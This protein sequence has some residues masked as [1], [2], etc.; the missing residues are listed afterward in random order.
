M[1]DAK[2]RKKQQWTWKK[3]LNSEGMYTL[4]APLHYL[5]LYQECVDLTNKEDAPTIYWIQ[6]LTLFPSD[7]KSLIN[8]RWISDVLIIAG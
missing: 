8:G 3:V 1:K 6:E 2:R 4:D 7:K 5:A